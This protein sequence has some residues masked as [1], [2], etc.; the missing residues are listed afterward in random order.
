MNRI[1][2]ILV[3]PKYPGNIG[4]V[5]R[6]MSNFDVSDLIMVD[7]IVIDQ[8]ARNRAKHANFILN[9]SR[10]VDTL[11]AAIMQTDLNIG[12]TGI[13]NTRQTGHIRNPLT[14]EQLFER[15]S[16]DAGRTW[17]P[18]ELTDLPSP[19]AALDAAR[20]DDGRLALVWNHSDRER[21]PLTLALSEDEGRS[22]PHVRDLVTGEG[23]FHYPA[24]IQSRDGRLHISFTN[25]RTT[26]DH[27]VLRP[28]WVEGK[29]E[30]L[31]PWDG[32]GRRL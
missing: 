14:P 27:V 16:E 10:T 12:T 15:F 4:A 18:A 30:G 25:N 2:V 3:R 1:S 7:P 26:I 9:N 29:G 21:N 11:D 13:K 31:R 20:L 8:E 5:A 17:T 22:W 28:E 6:V 32:S 19:F 24:I 23:Q